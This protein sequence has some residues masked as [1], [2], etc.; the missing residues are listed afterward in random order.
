MKTVEH[1]SESRNNHHRGTRSHCSADIIRVIPKLD[2]R[3]KRIC[4]SQKSRHR[5]QKLFI[6]TINENLANIV[7]SYHGIIGQLYLIEGEVTH[8]EECVTK[9]KK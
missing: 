2:R 6:W 8:T 3:R 1:K 5:S 9:K 7:K 4:E